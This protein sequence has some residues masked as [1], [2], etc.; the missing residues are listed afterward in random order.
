MGMRPS[1]RDF[2]HVGFCGGIGLTLADYFAMKAKAD[3]KKY[4]S[5]EGTAK[6]VIF[7][8][9]PGGSAHQETFD[10]KPYAPIEYRGPM[11]SIQTKVSGVFINEM[12]PQTAT[13]AD[14]IA[15][16]RSMTHGEAAHERQIA[17]LSAIVAVC[18]IISLMNTPETFVWIEFIGPR[19]SIGAYGFGSNVSW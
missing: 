9:L 6:S 8:Y 16:C 2:L 10:P 3:I 1:R 18:G 19:Y 13:I 15:I 12:M 17:I 11:N 4:E 5:K 14:K 7:I